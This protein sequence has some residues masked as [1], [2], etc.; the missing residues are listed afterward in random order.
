MI[1]FDYPFLE[2]DVQPRQRF[3]IERHLC[4]ERNVNQA[5]LDVKQCKNTCSV[6]VYLDYIY[7]GGK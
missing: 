5:L 3:L 7:L 1:L 6:G 4:Q 2:I